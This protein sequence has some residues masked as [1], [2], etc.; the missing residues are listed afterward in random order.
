M[1][2]SLIFTHRSESQ[3][4]FQGMNILKIRT[5]LKTQA[6]EHQTLSHFAL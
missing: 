4:W 5:E 2:G 6:G 3:D 1:T